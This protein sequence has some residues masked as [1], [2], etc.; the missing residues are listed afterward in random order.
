MNDFLKLLVPWQRTPNDQISDIFVYIIGIS[1]L[2]LIIY[3]GV[4][5][6]LQYQL[7]RSLTRKIRQF[8]RPAQPSI[9]QQLEQDFA[10]K[11]EFAEAWQEFEDSLVTRQRDE[12]QEVVYKT[13]EASYFFSED[14]LLGQYVNLRFW[15]SIPAILVGL[16]IL[17]TFVGLV[18]G[19]IPFSSIDF[20]NTEEIKNAIKELLS[21]VSTAFVTSVWGMVTSLLF[22]GV[23]KLAIGGINSEIANLQRSLDNLF[24]LTVQEKIAF[25]QADELAQQTAA[26]KSFSTDL[27]NDIKSAMAEGRQ[28]ILSELNKTVEAFSTTI[29][30]QLRPILE[31]LME[32]IE[33]LRQQK[34]ESSTD[35]I[36]KLIEEFQKSLSTST[37]TQMEELA[38]TV[39]EASQSLKDLPD[40]IGVMIASIQDQINQNR[41]LLTE[42]SHEQTAQMKSMMDEMIKTLQSVVELAAKQTEEQV[43]QQIEKMKTVSDESIQTLQTTI[44]ELRQSITD[45]LKQQQDAIGKITLQTSQASVDA[46]DQ[47]SQLIHQITTKL[48]ETV[49]AAES[50]INKLLEQQKG[51][52]ETFDAQIVNSRETLTSGKE[53]LEQMNTS[54][55][56]VR[57]IIE[58]TEAFSKQLTTG[59][60]QLESAGQ[61]LMQ[62]GVA[63]N[64][65]NE[66]YLTANRET[67]Q[68]LENLHGQSQQLLDNS[69]ERFQTIDEGLQSIFAEIDRGMNNYSVTARET[70]NSYLSDFSNQL[71]QAVAALSNSIEALD[72]NFEDLND[73]I[74]Q[75]MY[76]QDNK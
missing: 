61:Q 45:T 59:A 48:G 26:L 13:D 53:M 38:K 67:I 54:V 66:K 15:N 11:I 7:I 63:F 27:A 34:E 24:T 70:I 46:T 50:S 51:Q 10:R 58:T 62:A 52:I 71:S 37:V 64:Q 31:K 56:S 33:E 74:E 57:Q 8:N 75:L 36:G 49:Q 65:E 17:G 42:T 18:W 35:A 40:Q 14:R 55:S 29:L 73:R 22:N 69:T 30:E 6:L 5:I 12:N 23:E 21:G 43:D 16:G 20:Q 4:R 76:Q 60:D 25:Q 41:Q 47:M 72:D 1:F 32:A 2:V 9:K 19:L 3:F 39:G 68:Q 28:E 44:A